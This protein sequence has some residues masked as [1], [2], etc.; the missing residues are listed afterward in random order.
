MNP[1]QGHFPVIFYGR[2]YR[3][4]EHI[5]HVKVSQDILTIKH[6]DNSSTETTIFKD[7]EVS[8]AEL[9]LMAN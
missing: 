8:T 5:I 9:N 6:K 7:I 2:T 4:D 3:E 1:D